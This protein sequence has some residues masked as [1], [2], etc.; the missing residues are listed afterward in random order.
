MLVPRVHYQRLFHGLC[1]TARLRENK[2]S[3]VLSLGGDEFLGHQI[4]A[5]AEPSDQPN[6]RLAIEGDE[7]GMWERTIQVVDRHPPGVREASVNATDELVHLPSLLDILGNAAPRGWR[8]LD[9]ADSSPQ[10]RI[11]LQEILERQKPLPDSFRI[12]QAIDL[13]DYGVVRR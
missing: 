4:H 8:D 3:G 2:N 6:V 7:F 10:R 12:V 5:V 9:H 1:G 13:K 11:V